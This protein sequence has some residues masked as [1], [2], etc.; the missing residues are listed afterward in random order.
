[1][2]HTNITVILLIF[3]FFLCIYIYNK[4]M[5]G[6][7]PFVVIQIYCHGSDMPSKALSEPETNSILKMSVAGESGQWGWLS[8]NGI[9]RANVLIQHYLNDPRSRLKE[10]FGLDPNY[11]VTEGFTH[12]SNLFRIDTE[13]KR[14]LPPLT[15]HENRAKGTHPIVDHQY[16][17]TFDA[18]WE[19]IVGK[20][21]TGVFLVSAPGIPSQFNL[22]LTSRLGIKMGWGGQRGD[23]VQMSKLV[24]DVKRLF[25]TDY[26]GIIDFSCRAIRGIKKDAPVLEP[27]EMTRSVLENPH[28]SLIKPP[29]GG[30]YRRKSLNRTNKYRKLSRRFSRRRPKKM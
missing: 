2:R 28:H 22:D 1:M 19:K 25:N 15:A 14:L 11:C 9:A 16:H 23:V 3:D 6:K 18:D 20:K 29:R 30:G 26:V 5:S 12:I 27:W 24:A 7:L 21:N 4:N 17:F 13:Y 10:C 8:S